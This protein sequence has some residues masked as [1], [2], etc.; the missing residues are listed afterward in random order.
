MATAEG[1]PLFIE[2]LAASIQDD[3]VAGDLPPTIHAV[4]AARI[5]ALPGDARTALLRASV[6]GKVFWRGVLGGLGNTRR[7]PCTGRA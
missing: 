1:N 5:D 7:Q 2:E 4:L 3:A 6:I